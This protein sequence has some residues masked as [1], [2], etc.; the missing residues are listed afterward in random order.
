MMKADWIS[1]GKTFLANFSLIMTVVGTQFQISGRL[2]HF[3]VVLMRTVAA[4]NDGAR[5]EERRNSRW[6]MGSCRVG[7]DRQGLRGVVKPFDGHAAVPFVVSRMRMEVSD[8]RG[9]DDGNCT[10]SISECG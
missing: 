4:S 9:L 7:R 5:R 8:A 1:P 3:A 10:E 2:F 6:L